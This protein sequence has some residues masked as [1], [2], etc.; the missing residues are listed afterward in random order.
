MSSRR[1]HVID[2]RWLGGGIA[3]AAR[4]AAPLLFIRAR[5][6]PSSVWALICVTACSPFT[7]K[8]LIIGLPVSLALTLSTSVRAV[9]ESSPSPHACG[10]QLLLP[11]GLG[12]G[13]ADG[14]QGRSDRRY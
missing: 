13:F 9:G 12:T 5:I 1:P 8:P 10:V 11:Q 4:S 6:R 2:S 7:V 3:A 14:A